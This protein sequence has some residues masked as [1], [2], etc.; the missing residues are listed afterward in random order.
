MTALTQLALISLVR[1]GPVH[2][3][4]EGD[5]CQSEEKPQDPTGTTS[6]KD[7]LKAAEEAKTQS[8]KRLLVNQQK[9]SAVGSA[10][11]APLPKEVQ[12]RRPSSVARK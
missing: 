1:V 8:T 11:D 6:A 5:L 12:R 10:L 9:R 2:A 4:P 7:T 3:L